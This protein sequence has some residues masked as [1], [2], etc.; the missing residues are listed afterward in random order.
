MNMNDPKWVVENEILSPALSRPPFFQESWGTRWH[1]SGYKHLGGRIMPRVCVHLN[2]FYTT[3]VGPLS[4][5]HNAALR[6]PRGHSLCDSVCT[7]IHMEGTEAP[8]GTKGHLSSWGRATG[9]YS[10][11]VGHCTWLRAWRVPFLDVYL[12]AD[13]GFSPF[14]PAN[15]VR[16]RLIGVFVTSRCWEASEIALT[17]S[18]NRD[19]LLGYLLVLG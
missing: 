19:S 7:A 2:F 9:A 17:T 1:K 5:R 10:N 12:A 8:Q 13:I 3:C 18:A 4:T 15:P 14:Q 6:E 11:A 16:T